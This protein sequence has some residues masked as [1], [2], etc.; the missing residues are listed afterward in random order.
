MGT[1]IKEPA[2]TPI[3]NKP[4]KLGELLSIPVN[5]SLG[6]QNWQNKNDEINHSKW[7][8]ISDEDDLYEVYVLYL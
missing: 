4:A 1:T 3:L 8:P 2:L 6:V 5:I 7:Q